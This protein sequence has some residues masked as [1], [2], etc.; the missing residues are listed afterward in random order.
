MPRDR[1]VAAAL[2]GACLWPTLLVPPTGAAPPS[3]EPADAPSAGTLAEPAELTRAK[4]LYR[5]GQAKFETFDYV[6]A[7]DLWTRAYSELPE[8]PTN[9][10]V[11]ARLLFNISAARVAAYDIDHSAAHL[12]QAKKLMDK[13]LESIETTYGPDGS[14]GAEAREALEWMQRIDTLLR[15]IEAEEAE[16]RAASPGHETES[17][18]ADVTAAPDTAAVDRPPQRRPNHRA[19]TIAGAVVGGAGVAG[20]GVMTMGLLWGRAVEREGARRVEEDPTLTAAN[21]RSLTRQGRT[22]NVLTYVGAG[23]GGAMLAA[24]AVLL[25]LG[26]SRPRARTAAAPLLGPGT[27]GLWLGGRF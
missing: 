8:N 27:A 14:V 26:L 3:R 20:L 21:M 23:A 15:E 12:R 24:G 22:M 17:P 7:I 9:R 19:L 16:R 4:Q 25:G 2:C 18:T 5:E 13:Y 10:A 11:R 1:R 6:G